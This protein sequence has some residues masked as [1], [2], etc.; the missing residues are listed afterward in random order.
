MYAYCSRS[1][2]ECILVCV[3][4]LVHTK[5][6]RGHILVSET[7]K[8]HTDSPVWVHYMV[9][10]DQHLQLAGRLVAYMILPDQPVDE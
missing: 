3:H 1:T 2:N 8:I 10:C 7:G 6:A 5:C 9:P 4:K